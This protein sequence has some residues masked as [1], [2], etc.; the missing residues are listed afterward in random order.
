MIKRWKIGMTSWTPDKKGE[1]RVCPRCG[2]RLVELN[3]AAFRRH[4][5][6]CAGKRAA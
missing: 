4:V 1:R 2:H 5:V 6:T 3:R